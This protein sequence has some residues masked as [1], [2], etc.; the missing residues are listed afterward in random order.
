[1]A[2]PLDNWALTG[3]RCAAAA[4]LL[5]YIV[6]YGYV[7]DVFPAAAVDRLQLLRQSYWVARQAGPS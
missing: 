4:A 7:I 6:R 3:P 1:V 2:W 5:H